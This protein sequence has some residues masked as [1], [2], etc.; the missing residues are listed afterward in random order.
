MIEAHELSKAYGKTL[1]LDGVSVTI[2]RGGLT[3]IIGANGA[4]KSTLLSMISRLA[5]PDRGHV[6]LDGVDV[7]R[8]NGA[9]LARKLA[10]LRQ[11]NHLTARLTVRELVSFGRFPHCQG[12]PGPA[13]IA[14]IDHA[15]EYLDLTALAGRFLDELSGGQ[16]QRAFVAMVLAQETDY[17]L[18]DEP[19]NNLDMK[20]SRAMMR[21]LARTAHDLGRTVIVVLHDI[22]FASCHSDNI[23]AMKNGR[24]ARHGPPS[25]II[26]SE[27]LDLIYDMDIEVQQVNGKPIAFFHD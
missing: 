24:I 6:T 3:S 27:C 1:V 13:D 20:H 17:V 25:E 26:T 23:I 7:T 14:A 22:N 15:L 5:T 19:L 12:R 16:R 2:P 4:G 8:A 11:D 21:M 9:E 18:L 10:I